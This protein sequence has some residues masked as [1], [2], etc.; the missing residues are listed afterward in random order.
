VVNSTIRGPVIIGENAQVVNSYIGPFTSV[1]FNT[2]ISNSE[3][4]HSI[5]LENST[6]RDIKRLED[7]LIG[8]NVRL[9]RTEKKPAAFRIMVGDS[10]QV[11]II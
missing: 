7:S 6:I 1:Y 5:I 11:E 10:S 3:I 4:E 8:Q 2:V 9:S